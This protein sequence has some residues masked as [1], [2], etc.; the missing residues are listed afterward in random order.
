ML[1]PSIALF[2]IPLFAFACSDA[3]PSDTPDGATPDDDAQVALP[4][5]GTEPTDA[6]NP[7]DADASDGAV[8]GPGSTKGTGGITC[9]SREDLGNGRSACVT[10][11]LGSEIKLVEPQGGTG[12]LKLGAYLHGDGAAAHKSNSA[13]K[14]LLPWADKN[15]AL[16]VSVLSP[17]KCAWWQAPTQTDCSASATP[18]ADADGLNADDFKGVL[19]KIRSAYDVTLGNAY[20]YGSSGGSVFLTLHFFRKYGDGFPGIYALNCGGEKPMK[21]IGWDTADAAKRAGTKLFFTYG[22]QDFL[23]PDI[24]VAI[25]YFGG[26]GFPTD[27]KVIAGA[28]HCE[29]DG[30]GRAAEI[31]EANVPK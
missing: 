17:N 30:H 27:T 28:G 6:Q 10:T 18:V 14:A 3:A 4:D 21:P 13:I 8:P 12:P 22:D 19:D 25:P 24:E 7:G 23:K 29:F 15:H 11:I 26:L 9:T 5:G 1:R 2:A 31:F 16:V 20:Y